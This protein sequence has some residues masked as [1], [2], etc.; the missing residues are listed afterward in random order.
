MYAPSQWETTLQCNV[1]SQCGKLNFWSTHPKT[2]VPNMFC[3]KCHSPGPDFYLPSSKCTHI[4]ERGSV[5]L[6]L[7]GCIHKM[8]P[9]VE[10]ASIPKYYVMAWYCKTITWTNDGNMLWCYM[11]W[12]GLCG[13]KQLSTYITAYQHGT[14]QASDFMGIHSAVTIYSVLPKLILN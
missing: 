3:A 13:L 8:T 2:D 1:I 10:L 12:L 7:A 14:T 11:T 6:V 4:G 5:S 9:V